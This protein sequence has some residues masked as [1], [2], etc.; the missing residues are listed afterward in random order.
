MERSS[1]D[2]ATDTWLL[3]PEE[4]SCYDDTKPLLQC[5]ERYRNS[6]FYYVR[7][8][9]HAQFLRER[10]GEAFLILT[11]ASASAASQPDASSIIRVNCA[12]AAREAEQSAAAAATAAANATNAASTAATSSLS[13]GAEP[14]AV[15]Q[16]KSNPIKGTGRFGSSLCDAEGKKGES[17]ASQRVKAPN[18]QSNW[19]HFSRH[20]RTSRTGPLRSAFCRRMLLSKPIRGL[21][22]VGQHIEV[23]C[24]SSRTS[25]WRTALVVRNDAAT[26]RSIIKWSDGEL[27]TLCPDVSEQKWR[28][29]NGPQRRWG[30][31][32]SKRNNPWAL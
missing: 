3:A 12:R 21:P 11:R 26:R 6:W 31:R 9:E 10:M 23:L 15:Q 18:G 14:Q 25:G 4:R 2:Q 24:G 5:P 16:Q 29:L 1:K 8:H 19:Y 27:F 17:S 28:N 7:G 22:R 20:S 13:P 30:H 32:R